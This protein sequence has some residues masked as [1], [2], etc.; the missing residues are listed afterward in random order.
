MSNDLTFK[1][2]SSN[3]EIKPHKNGSSQVDG[4][5][6]NYHIKEGFQSEISLRHLIANS[7]K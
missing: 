2:L 3:G 7:Q 1:P 6:S 4:L 5:S